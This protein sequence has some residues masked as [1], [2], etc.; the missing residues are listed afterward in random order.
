MHVLIF[1]RRLLQWHCECGQ[2]ITAYDGA[3]T[4]TDVHRSHVEDVLSLASLKF[5]SRS[6]RL[7]RQVFVDAINKPLNELVAD[8]FR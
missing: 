7:D 2:I 5:G 1:D 8:I 6:Q 3:A 4:I